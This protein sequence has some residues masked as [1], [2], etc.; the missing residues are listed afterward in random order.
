MND[1]MDY[2]FASKNPVSNTQKTWKQG[3]RMGI[4]ST[5][6]R[7]RY[8]YFSMGGLIPKETSSLKRVGL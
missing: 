7:E 8:K 2:N 6:V 1:W 5:S 4:F 3:K